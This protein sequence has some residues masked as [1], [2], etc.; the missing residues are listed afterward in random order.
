MVQVITSH[1]VTISLMSTAFVCFKK[2]HP[3]HIKIK[4]RSY[5]NNIECKHNPFV[6]IHLI[7]IVGPAKRIK[8]VPYKIFYQIKHIVNYHITSNAMRFSTI[9]CD[10]DQ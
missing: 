9:C 2:E 8:N 4:M 10:E 3:F 6:N 7:N 5:L 1:Y